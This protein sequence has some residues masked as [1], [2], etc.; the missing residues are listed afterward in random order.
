MI[1]IK[2]LAIVVLSGCFACWAIACAA[3]GRRGLE[4]L[5]DGG[6]DA[7]SQQDTGVVADAM[8]SLDVAVDAA[9]PCVSSEHIFTD[10]TE[11]FTVPQD[12]RY[13]VIKAW[14][15]GANEEEQCVNNTGMG[16]PGGYTAA[17]L[18]VSA[19]ASLITA[20]STLSVVVGRRVQ[21]NESSTELA[22]HGFAASGGGGLSGVFTGAFPL[23][24]SEYGRAVLIAGGGGSAGSENAS[25]CTIGR[26]GNSPT[27]GGM[28]NMQGGAGAHDDL[29]GGGGGYRGGL[30]GAWGL[31]GYGGEE[32]VRSHVDVLDSR[33]EYQP[34]GTWTAPMTSDPDYNGTAGASQSSGLV[35]IRFV[36]TLPSI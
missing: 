3:G 30:G 22:L 4:P 8:V 21:L 14:G 33:V 9:D 35:V 5:N 2:R 36:C 34:Q 1:S 10:T 26:P 15:S 12:V 19:S 23:T 16:G 25:T 7:T 28:N 18:D 27:A 17:L 24:A 6:V 31:S 29:N 32:F 20:G 11:S 13:M